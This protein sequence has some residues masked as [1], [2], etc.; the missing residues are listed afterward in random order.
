M[1][2][3]GTETFAMS[4]DMEEVMFDVTSDNYYGHSLS[5]PMHL[6]GQ[7]FTELLSAFKTDA[8]VPYTSYGEK[9]TEFVEISHARLYKTQAKG[10]LTN[11]EIQDIR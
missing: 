3:R 1:Q 10:W 5:L 8:G 2:V 11:P 6:T 9:F 4:A 7:P